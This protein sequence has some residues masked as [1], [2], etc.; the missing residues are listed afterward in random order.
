[1]SRGKKI[2]ELREFHLQLAFAG[3]RVHRENVEDQLRAVD[4]AR[5]DDFLHVAKLHGSEVVIDDHE[6]DILQ[7]G[8]VANFFEFAAAYERGGIE[9]VANLQQRTAD[10]RAGGNGQLFE[11]FERIAAQGA[12]IEGA[13]VRSFLQAHA[14]EQHAF[15]IIDGL[16]R[17]H[18]VA[19]PFPGVGRRVFAEVKDIQTR[20]YAHCG[21][22]VNATQ[23]PAKRWDGLRGG[24]C[25]V[26][27]GGENQIGE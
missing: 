25:G 20:L 12:R 13:P 19:I 27:R 21:W 17:S 23:M 15:A 8:F 7:L 9:R 10:F 14:D 3:A 11:F 6:R 22:C 24:R 4:H 26:L 1:M 2:I 16:R 18:A 5:A